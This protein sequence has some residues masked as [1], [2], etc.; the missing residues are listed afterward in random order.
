MSTNADYEKF[1]AFFQNE[2][3]IFLLASLKLALS[4][5]GPDLTSDG[6]FSEEDSAQGHIIAK[7]ALLVCGLPLIPILIELAKSSCK[8]HLNVEEGEIV[9]KDTTIAIIQGPAREMLRLERV[10]LN[11][12]GHLSGIASLTNQ[13]VVALKDSTTTLLDTRKT[14]PCLR[15][16]EKYAVLTGGAENHRKNLFEMI[17]I[18]D[19]HI[20]QA[21]SITAAVTTLTEKYEKCPPIEVECRNLKEV[22]EAIKLPIARIMF[23]NMDVAT[24]KEAQKLVPEN[25]QTEISGNVSLEKLAELST[26]GANYISVGKIT[27]SAAS[28]DL[29]MKIVQL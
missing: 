9:A 15:Y 24:M 11:F 4:E 16:L 21:G 10:F 8:F 6:I 17:M 18:K 12:I 14:T 22:A 27:H 2:S 3:K 29:S 28:K 1:T 5:D 7:E 20:D 25:I 23:D 26:V 19:N 13:Y